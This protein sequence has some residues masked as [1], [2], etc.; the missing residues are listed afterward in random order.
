MKYPLAIFVLLSLVLLFQPLHAE[1]DA[2]RDTSTPEKALLGHWKE[3]GKNAH[4]YFDVEKLIMTDNG[5]RVYM[6]Y[7]V[8]SAHDYENWIKI[9]VK[10]G[11]RKG[12]IKKLEYYWGYQSLTAITM[13]EGKELESV[14]YYVDDQR[15]PD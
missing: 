7:R 10:T 12:H 1:E 14:W 5:L 2:A 8:I 4:Y 11:R 13:L 9:K 3:A 6:K 15:E